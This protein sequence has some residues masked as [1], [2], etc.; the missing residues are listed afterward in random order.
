MAGV[1]SQEP[2]FGGRLFVGLLLLALGTGLLLVELGIFP[3]S[4]RDLWPLGVVVVGFWIALKAIGRS[5]GRGLTA[6]IVTLAVG[7]YYLA[8][9]LT[10]LTDQYFLPVILLALG[11]GV[12]LRALVYANR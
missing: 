1:K 2:A 6:G 4:L 11:L 9:S 3:G 7:G 8:V 10:E 12:T 5:D